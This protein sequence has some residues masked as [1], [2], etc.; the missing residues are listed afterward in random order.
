MKDKIDK[1]L[2]DVT[3]M[4]DSVDL[5]DTDILR[6]SMEMTQYI[7]SCLSL[8]REIIISHSPLNKVDEIIFFKEQKPEVLSKL[9]YFNLEF[10]L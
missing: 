3:E 2:L 8:L 9:L 7:Q 6:R 4:S 5:F 1:I 10:N